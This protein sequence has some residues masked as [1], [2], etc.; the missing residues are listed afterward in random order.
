MS[1]GNEFAFEVSYS[2]GAADG[3]QA[4]AYARQVLCH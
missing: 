1:S 4:L 2:D 3:A